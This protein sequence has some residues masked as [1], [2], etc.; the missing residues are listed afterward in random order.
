MDAGENPWLAMALNNAWANR[1]L[2]DAVKGLSQDAF[3]A[4][5]PGFFRSLWKTLNHVY[6]VD[7]YYIDALEAGGRG[8]AVYDR[9]EVRDAATLSV[10]QAEADMRFAA[11]CRAMTPERLSET[12]VTERDVGRIEETVA[13]LILHLVQHQVHHRGQAHVQL[14]D[15]GVAPP[16][17]DE[18]YLEYD[19]AETAGGYWR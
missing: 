5:R 10:L 15:A 7:L 2:Y 8:L 11:F 19:R 1:T 17:L 14:Q 3:I 4:D 18:F 16:Q 9:D 12:R 6:E 13:A